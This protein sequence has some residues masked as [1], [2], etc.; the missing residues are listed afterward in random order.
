ML[1]AALLKVRCHLALSTFCRR[2]DLHTCRVLGA[3]LGMCAPAKVGRGGRVGLT[4]IER[5]V[6][7]RSTCA[8]GGWYYHPSGL[9]SHHRPK[10]I[11]QLSRLVYGYMLHYSCAL[12][13][14]R[15]SRSGHYHLCQWSRP[16]LLY[17]RG[18]GEDKKYLW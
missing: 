7:H 15:R 3:R 2:D 10:S 13:L 14:Q 16:L 1:E 4:C 9:I 12:R 8:R 18:G 5:G 6:K 17:C 11:A